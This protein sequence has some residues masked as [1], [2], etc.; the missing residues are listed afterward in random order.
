MDSRGEEKEEVK[1]LKKAL[2]VVAI[3]LGIYL[4]FRF[5]LPLVIPF[6]IAGLVSVLYYPFLRKLY[7]KSDI[8]EGKNKKWILVLSVV[9]FYLVVMILF[10]LLC[11]YVVNQCQSIW[12]NLPFY[13]ARLIGVVQDCCGYVD[14]ILRMKEGESFSYVEN[15]VEGIEIVNVTGILPKVTSYSVQFISSIFGMVFEVVIT[16]MATFFLIQD[17]ERIRVKMLETSVGH[18]VCRVIAKCKETLGA[19]LKAQGFI[20]LLDGVLCTLAF[21]LIGQPYYLV[22]GPLVGVLDALPILG[23]GAFLIPYAI[24]LFL[25]S[26]PGGALV[27]ILAYIGCVVIR[28]LTEPRMIG[29]K[30]EMRPVFTLL[31]MYV[32]FQLFGVIGFL[33]GPVGV[34]IGLELYKGLNINLLSSEE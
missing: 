22:L 19:Y 6:V 2:L 21:L 24:F 16:I 14:L 30:M 32:G 31:S 1:D 28:Q 17:Y 34:L 13:Q 4:A 27:V 15:V 25:T 33:L 12:L 20:M 26:K 5:L 8:W 11:N 29:S 10:G 23:A 18:S 3:T 7:K 9:L